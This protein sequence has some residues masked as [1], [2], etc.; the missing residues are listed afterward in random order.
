M[1]GMQPSDDQ[2]LLPLRSEVGRPAYLEYEVT[3]SKYDT[4]RVELTES[5]GAAPVV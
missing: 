3:R 4:S 5:S 2:Y 1:S